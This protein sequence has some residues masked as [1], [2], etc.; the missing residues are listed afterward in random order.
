[1]KSVYLLYYIF[2][3]TESY[4]LKYE[5]VSR[6]EW[7]ALPP[8]VKSDDLVHPL[9]RVMIYHTV[10]HQCFNKADCFE[11]V[12]NI[13]T[14]HLNQNYG[15]IGYNFL[16]GGDGRAYVGQGW[17][18]M[19]AHFIRMVLFFISFHLKIMQLI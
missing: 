8:T 9:G 14:G 10:T 3:H 4:S 13:Q 15:D 6:D 12:R 5:L 19:G 17:D 7:K 18:L 1:M 2:Q 16:I 11:Q